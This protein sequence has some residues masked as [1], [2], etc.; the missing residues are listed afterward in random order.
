MVEESIERRTVSGRP[1]ARILIVD[2]AEQ[3]LRLYELYLKEEFD[4]SITRSGRDA[5]D[6]LGTE[7]FDLALV[8]VVMPGMGGIE[9]CQRLKALPHTAGIPVIF[10]TGRSIDSSDREIAFEVGA[11]DYLTKPVERQELVARVRV[12]LRFRAE[13]DELARKYDALA[14]AVRRSTSLVSTVAEQI[15]DYRTLLEGLLAGVIGT[16]VVAPSGMI[17]AASDVAFALL[18]DLQPG[19]PV[20]EVGSGALRALVGAATDD[21]AASRP[22]FIELDPDTRLA[23]TTQRLRGQEGVVLLVRDASHELAVQNHLADR[24]PYDVRRESAELAAQGQSSYSISKFVGNSPVLAEVIQQIGQLRHSRC[25]V[26]IVG[27]SGSGKELVA[28]ALHYD[29]EFGARPFTPIHCG[30]ISPELI[31]SE[32]FGH[33]KGAFTGATERKVGLFEAT[34]GGTVFL[35]EIA[36]TSLS[37]QIK[38]LR[39]LQSGEIRPVGATRPR[40]VDVRIIAATN[41]DLQTL[42]REGKFREDLFYRL[43][44]V[45]LRIPPLRE[46]KDDIPLLIHH[47]MA[48]CNSRYGRSESPISEVSRGAMRAIMNHSWPGNVR[49]LENVIER[50]FALG[51]EGIIELRDLP[52]WARAPVTAAAIP[53]VDPLPQ[54]AV[55]PPAAPVGRSLREHARDHERTLMREALRA[56]GGN[57]R[58]ARARLGM[59]RSTFYR[60]LRELELEDG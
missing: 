24:L 26:L 14:R 58:I 13:R 7:R 50:A 34:D 32:L 35:D 4:V 42:V 25:N 38:L 5:L 59:A 45:T 23:V 33:E 16:V 52:H 37:L 8:D 17:V 3:N 51:A 2:D 30:A 12:M 21:E 46:R 1:K 28:L 57:R 36:E 48:K 19:R 40:Y 54:P 55:T 43:D 39:V 60:R 15:D 9:L 49:E 22:R 10:F 29:G 41:R 56:S 18:P 6:M 20:A 27:E 11:V 31:E 47:F 53:V 44:V